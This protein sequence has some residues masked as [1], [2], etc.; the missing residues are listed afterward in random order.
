LAPRRPRLTGCAWPSWVRFVIRAFIAVEIDPQVIDKISAAIN[1]LKSRVS[2]VRWVNATN[3]HLTLKFLG[4]V[5]ET[6]INQIGAALEAQL[7]PFPRFTINAK[8]LGVFPDLRRPRILW[9]G[10]TGIQLA[11]LVSRLESALEPL[12]FAPEKRS[13]TPH[14]SIG[15]WRQTDRA[16]KTLGQALESWKD[17]QFGA[18]NVDEV[19]LFHSKLNPEGAIHTKLQI[20]TLTNAQT[21]E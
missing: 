7:H 10:L 8:G 17:Y 13:F 5:E 2:G 14:L 21:G 19:I 12:G 4:D 3:I 6:Q 16:S 1:Q 20:V 9:V 15:R 11:S 18:T